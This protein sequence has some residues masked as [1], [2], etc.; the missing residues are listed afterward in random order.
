MKELSLNILDIAQNSITAGATFIDISLVETNKELSISV[1]DD[2]CGMSDELIKR[3]SDPFYTT[4]TTRKVGLG[5]PFLKM[6]AEQT[7]G[8]VFIKSKLK[9]DFPDCHGTTIISTFN[10]NHLDFTPLGD[11][12]S[13]ICVL[14]HGADK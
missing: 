3:V 2:G 9:S 10:K 13:T 6:E 12:I 11:I 8:S 5:I 7:G 14:I 1:S 4:R